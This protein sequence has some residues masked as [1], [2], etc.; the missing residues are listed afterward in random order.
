MIQK[1][2]GL[3]LNFGSVLLP[4]T[5]K[6]IVGINKGREERMPLKTLRGDEMELLLAYRATTPQAAATLLGAARMY[7]DVFPRQDG[8]DENTKIGEISLALLAKTDGLAAH[9]VVFQ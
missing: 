2:R 5:N 6:G 1:I 4:N 7:A 9:P 8:R 3:I